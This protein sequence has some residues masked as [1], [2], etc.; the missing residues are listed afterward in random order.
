MVKIKCDIIQD[1]IPSYVDGVCSDATRECVEEHMKSCEGCRKMAA[2]CRENGISGEQMEQKELDGLKKIKQITRYKGIACCGLVVFILGSMNINIWGNM[3][4]GGISFLLVMF[5]TCICLVLLSGLGFKGKQAPGRLEVIL[6]IVSFV[7]AFYMVMLNL[8]FI[9][10]VLNG[11]DCVFGMEM[12]KMGPFFTWQMG[13]GHLV[14]LGFF[15]W[16]LT[17]AIRQDRNCNWLMCL[18]VAGCYIVT[19]CWRLLSNMWAPEVF[20]RVFI[21]EI[22]VVTAIGLIGVLMSVL[23]GKVSRRRMQ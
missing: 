20:L 5:I 6:G 8:Y 7:I 15:L 14:M 2:L 4:T 19:G 13:L 23:I 11:A 18:D 16:H 10:E 3:W 9:E 22:S 1:L 12:Y 21:E 17:G